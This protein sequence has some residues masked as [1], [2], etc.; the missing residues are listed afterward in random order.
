[1]KYIVNVYLFFIIDIDFDLQ[2]KMRHKVTCK[3]PRSV[4]VSDSQFRD[5]LQTGYYK[6]S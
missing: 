5:G 3:L 1:M 4:L 6:V 2:E